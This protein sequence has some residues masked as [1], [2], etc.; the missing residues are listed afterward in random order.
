MTQ[1]VKNLPEM[2]EAWEYTFIPGW[3]RFPW[4]RKRQ[5]TPVFMPGQSHGQRS[6]VGYSPWGRKESDTSERLS[7]RSCTPR[8]YPES[9]PSGR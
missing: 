6:F 8:G 2:Q 1:L 4:R 3:G 5:P 7:T 9:L